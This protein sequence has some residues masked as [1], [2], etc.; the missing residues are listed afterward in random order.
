[1]SSGER[2][3]NQTLL[4]CATDVTLSLLSTF[5]PAINSQSKAKKARDDAVSIGRLHNRRRNSKCEEP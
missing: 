2:R 5:P 3:I 4:F 1:M